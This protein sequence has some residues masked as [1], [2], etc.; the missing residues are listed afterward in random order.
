MG[1]LRELRPDLLD[2]GREETEAL[3]RVLLLEKAM[4]EI[5]YE[6]N[7]RPD[8]VSIPLQAAETLLAEAS[9]EVGR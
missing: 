8:W 2:A 4:Y 6:L 9:G 5:A 3:L 7:S 1:V